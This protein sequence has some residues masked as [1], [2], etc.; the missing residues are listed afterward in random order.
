MYADYVP[1]TTNLSI[2]FA[3][4]PKMNVSTTVEYKQPVMYTTL[5]PAET[6]VKE[7]AEYFDTTV[8][9]RTKPVRNVRC[10]ALLCRGNQT[11]SWLREKVRNFFGFNRFPRSNNSGF[12]FNRVT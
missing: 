11:E 5:K 2:L 9:S 7:D 3:S 10:N 8:Q 12:E 4:R 1:M 6:T